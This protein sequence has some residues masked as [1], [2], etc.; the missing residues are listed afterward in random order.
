VHKLSTLTIIGLFISLGVFGQENNPQGTPEPQEEAPAALFDANLDDETVRYEF[1]G[2]WVSQLS[3]GLG[4]ENT[5]LGANFFNAYPGIDRGLILI[6]T[7]N[8]VLDLWLYETYFFQGQYQGDDGSNEFALG[9]QGKEEDWLK[10]LQIGNRPGSIRPFAGL[11]ATSVP[12]GTPSIIFRSG[13]EDL[14]ADALLR[15]RNAGKK[16][17]SFRGAEK[18]VIIWLE[19]Q[20]Y[21]SGRFYAVP[22]NPSSIEVWRAEEGGSLLESASGSRYNLVPDSEYNY[23]DGVI[24]FAEAQDQSLLLHYSGIGNYSDSATGFTLLTLTASDARDYLLLQRGQ[25]GTVLELK[26]RYPLS[27]PYDSQGGLQLELIDQGTNQKVALSGRSLTLIPGESFFI[28]QGS[29]GLEAFPFAEVYPDLYFPGKRDDIFPSQSFRVETTTGATGYNLG[30]NA[31]PESIEVSVAGRS[32]QNFTFND[33]TGIL[34]IGSPVFPQD[35]VII[36]FQEDFMG[37]QVSEEISLIHSGSWDLE[38]WGILEW[39]SLLDWTFPEN[40]YSVTPG[41]YPGSMA[42]TALWKHNLGPIDYELTL[43]ASLRSED[44]SGNLALDGF[45]TSGQ[46]IV[47]DPGRIQPSPLPLQAIV[48]SGQTTWWDSLPVPVDNTGNG[49]VPVPS[50]RGRLYF[51]NHLDVDPLGN[52]FR[53]SYDWGGS[54]LLA[55]EDGGFS[56]P[57]VAGGDSTVPENVL[58]ME[59]EMDGPR[60]WVGA[61]V[62][63][64]SIRDLSQTSEITF[65]LRN[66]GENPANLRLF[67][68]A[69]ELGEDIN[70]DGVVLSTYSGVPGGFRFVDQIDNFS[71]TI[72][73][74]SSS[75][76]SNDANKNGVL[77]S[78]NPDSI[79]FREITS[80]PAVGTGWS[81]VRLSLSSEERALLSQTTGLRLILLKTDAPS[82]HSGE[83]VFSPITFQGAGISTNGDLSLESPKESNLI[84]SPSSSLAS[85]LQRVLSPSDNQ[86]LLLYWPAATTDW[87][88]TGDLRQASPDHYRY[89]D[90]YYILSAATGTPTFTLRVND[91]DLLSFQPP[92]DSEWQRLRIDLQEGT[93]VSGSLS[94]E[95]DLPPDQRWQSWGLQMSSAGSSGT[96]V[97]D[98]IGFSE[99]LVQGD[100]GGELLLTYPWTGAAGWL[101]L[102][103]GTLSLWQNYEN[104]GFYQASLSSE[105]RGQDLRLDLAID[106]IWETDWTT[107]LRY[108]LH[109]LTEEWEAQAEFDSSGFKRENIQLFL[110]M[111]AELDVSYGA[112]GEQGEKD[113]AFAFGTPEEGALDLTL[114]TTV[115]QVSDQGKTP[116]VIRELWLE[117]WQ[118]YNPDDWDRWSTFLWNLQGVAG[119]NTEEWYFDLILDQEMGYAKP[120]GAPS[121]SPLGPRCIQPSGCRKSKLGGTTANL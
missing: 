119:Y 5:P 12:G 42:G 44:V 101:L 29:T 62:S 19:P 67:L 43:R 52:E 106:A 16:T 110:P 35:L 26:N 102:E 64:P 20:D 97:L 87:S 90:L 111:A 59:Y 58:S 11:G 2:S 79:L 98:E 82:D 47:W 49:D 85:Q 78:D 71:M 13:F 48:Y 10:L 1:S 15:Y 120:N 116:Q 21:I 57:Y 33:I 39:N 66:E 45:D 70:G 104:P 31:I 89:F 77:D 81:E 114:N 88:V 56:G 50:T 54:T 68:M 69:G 7:P 14:Q 83:L 63:T 40:T 25:Q 37:G 34:T 96:L 93:W 27:S 107:S 74:Q 86:V 100:W 4:G 3:F 105:M 72:P 76:I 24:Q 121:K 6:Q 23:R 115:K 30:N 73:R 55:Y 80:I 36:Q 75:D 9:Y 103:E 28:F 109:Y 22:G 53:Q 51:Q 61:Q 99:A 41:Q 60:T 108:D 65:S 32:T 94:G 17:L 38:D 84:P 112:L 91:Q 118:A 113:W 117:R 92:V 8:V 46:T 95:V 18:V